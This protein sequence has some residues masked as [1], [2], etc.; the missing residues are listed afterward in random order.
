[1]F[2][3]V[4]YRWQTFLPLMRLRFTRRKWV[5]LVAARNKGR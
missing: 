3:Y 4:L 2:F 1:M 5:K